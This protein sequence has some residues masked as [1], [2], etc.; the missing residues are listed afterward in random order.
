MGWNQNEHQSTVV[1]WHGPFSWFGYEKHNGLEQMPNLSGIYLWTFEYL[2]GYL[3]YCAGITKSTHQRFRQH[4]REYKK[5]NYTIFDVSAAQKGERAEIWHGWEYARTHR[6]EFE[7][8]KAEISR[9][10]E[11]Q[12]KSFRVFVANLE[13]QRTRTR[14]EAAIMH[15]IYESPEPWAKLADRGMSLSKK[16]DSEMPIVVENKAGVKIYGLQSY[17]KI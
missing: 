17:L 5:G 12:L 6:E 3:L 14:L 1:D 13:D 4:T 11:L 8:R 10:I 15:S 9:A 7:D 2:D 16:W